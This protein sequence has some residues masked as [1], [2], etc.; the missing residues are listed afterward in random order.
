MTSST[1]IVALGALTGW[2]LIAA[3]VPF[4]RFKFVV[5]MLLV[6]CI[7]ASRLAEAV[8]RGL[9]HVVAARAGEAGMLSATLLALLG[10]GLILEVE[11]RATH[12][13]GFHV[14][15][16]VLSASAMYC[17]TRKYR[18]EVIDEGELGPAG[19]IVVRPG[20]AVCRCQRRCL[21]ASTARCTDA[22]FAG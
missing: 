20:S 3:D 22:R 2:A 19:E 21:V 14:M 11:V 4:Q 13:V 17:L 7:T 9:G 8:L 6:P 12:A 15:A 1:V 18:L 5:A 10:I 16:A